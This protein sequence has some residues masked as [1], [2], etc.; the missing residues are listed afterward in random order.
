MNRIINAW[1]VY[2]CHF[3]SLIKPVSTSLKENVVCIRITDRQKTI[4]FLLKD[5][6]SSSSS[7]L[8]CNPWIEL[9]P[10]CCVLCPWHVVPA[11]TLLL[12]IR[13]SIRSICCRQLMPK[14][15]YIF[16]FVWFD[17]NY[18]G[19]SLYLYDLWELWTAFVSRWK[20]R[21]LAK[22]L[23][24]FIILLFISVLFIIEQ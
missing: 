22:R 23:P 16:A 20:C 14:H 7:Y 1:I 11:N 3:K 17:G 2:K 19:H 4:V 6:S 9:A 5:S 24:F 18:D 21:G 13:W 12:L 15:K 10:F 8:T